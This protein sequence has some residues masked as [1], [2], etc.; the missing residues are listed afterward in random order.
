[1][2]VRKELITIGMAFMMVLGIAG[3]IATSAYSIMKYNQSID[4]V[5][6]ESVIA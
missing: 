1:M 6:V 4:P 3:I 2:M 5:I